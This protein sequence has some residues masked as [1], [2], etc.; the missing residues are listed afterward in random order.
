M[1]ILI[2][3]SLLIQNNESLS[4]N[5]PKADKAAY[6]QANV[7]AN[8]YKKV[9]R[10]QFARR[11]ADLGELSAFLGLNWVEKVYFINCHQYE[12]QVRLQ[13]CQAQQYHL[14][15]QSPRRDPLK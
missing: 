12:F 5:I 15:H 10:R 3:V 4:L 1:K 7:N 9:M 2:F 14:Q 11:S 13:I 6:A 8:L